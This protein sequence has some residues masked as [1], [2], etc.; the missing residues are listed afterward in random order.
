MKVENFCFQGYLGNVG[1]VI[2]RPRSK[3]FRICRAPMRIRRVFRRAIDDRPY[4]G[5]RKNPTKYAGM[6][7]LV[8]SVDLGSTA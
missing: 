2:N 8:D 4:K 3:M 6:V 7:E 5:N 1:A